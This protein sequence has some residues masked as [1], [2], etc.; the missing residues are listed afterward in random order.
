RAEADARGARGD[1]R[2][3]C[4]RVVDGRRRRDRRMLLPRHQL[5]AHLDG[6]D[7]VLGKPDRFE[8][9]LIGCDGCVEPE[10]R[11]QLPER[12]R[13]LHAVPLIPASTSSIK[14]KISATFVK[15]P[16]NVTFHSMMCC[17]PAA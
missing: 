6:E 7:K 13:E 15:S 10:M 4:G 1:E 2:Q 17:A 9:E 16:R 8:A 5:S 3:I 12:D 11:I 14:W